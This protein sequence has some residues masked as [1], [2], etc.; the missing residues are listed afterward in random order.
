MFSNV[1]VERLTMLTHVT[2]LQL[3]FGQ[4]IWLEHCEWLHLRRGPG[5][6]DQEDSD[7]RYMGLIT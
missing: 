4:K 7:N 5:K 1:Y 6:A 2:N 3:D